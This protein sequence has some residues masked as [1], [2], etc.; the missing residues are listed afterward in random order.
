MVKYAII[1]VAYKELSNRLL[2]ELQNRDI[3]YKG[4]DKPHTIC[5]GRTL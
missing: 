5:M 3:R 1:E 2:R 4:K